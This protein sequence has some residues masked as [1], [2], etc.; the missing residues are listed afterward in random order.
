MHVFTMNAKE[1]QRILQSKINYTR[2][3][4]VLQTTY[5][6]IIFLLF[7]NNLG[8]CSR[9]ALKDYHYY[10]RQ[11]TDIMHFA[12][13]TFKY[14]HSLSGDMITISLFGLAAYLFKD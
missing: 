12:E 5:Q 11:Y 1:L 8:D 3:S 10:G 2:T 7:V 14:E 6:N 9:N 4:K 13:L